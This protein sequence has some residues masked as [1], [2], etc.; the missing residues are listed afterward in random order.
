MD[1]QMVTARPRG[2]NY[3]WLSWGQR[4][5]TSLWYTCMFRMWH[6]VWP[7]YFQKPVTTTGRL[8]TY[9]ILLV[10]DVP[11]HCYPLSFYPSS[12]SSFCGLEETKHTEKS[13]CKPS[14]Y[15]NQ[16]QH[17]V[18]PS[19]G[20]QDMEAW[21]SVRDTHTHVCSIFCPFSHH[22]LFNLHLSSVWCFL[23]GIKKTWWWSPP[24]NRR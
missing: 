14:N 17:Q 19:R 20:F 11:P 4:P 10:P 9:P 24:R 12:S 5:W 18:Y 1:R 7:S 2:L 22:C 6:N 23:T 16:W 8:S 13:I 21:R 3:N 15:K